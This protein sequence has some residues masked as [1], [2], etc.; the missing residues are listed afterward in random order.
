[1]PVDNNVIAKMYIDAVHND[2]IEVA[3]LTKVPELVTCNDWTR[4]EVVGA[5]DYVSER[6]KA[7]YNGLLVK[8]SG[9]LYFVRRKLADA[10]GAIDKRFKN[11]KRTVRV[12]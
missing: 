5:V 9:G 1:M 10:L 7:V 2:A 11:V 4:V 3:A 8:Y 6:T 12:V